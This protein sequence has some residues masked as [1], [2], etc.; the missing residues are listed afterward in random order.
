MRLADLALEG[1]ADPQ[2]RSWVETFAADG[3]AEPDYEGSAV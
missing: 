2:A 3:R 1:V